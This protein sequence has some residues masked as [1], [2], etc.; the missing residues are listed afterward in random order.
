MADEGYAVLTFDFRGYGES[1]GDQDFD[2]LDEDLKAAIRFMRV[3]R[4]KAPVFLI[5]ASMGATTSLVVAQDED[6]GGV[7][8]VSPPAEFESQN[9][10]EAISDVTVP[11]L[12]VATEDDA[13]ALALEQV[14]E[15]APD[16]VDTELY[17]GN[18]HGTD[19]L[20]SEHSTAFRARILSFL[21]D[22]AGS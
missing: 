5:G 11:V 16:S 22:H 4:G 3:D 1:D 17:S 2:K 20:Q 14:I 19:L 7:I 15:A 10:V 8:A 13:P 9:A 6:L 21:R 18:A 12:I